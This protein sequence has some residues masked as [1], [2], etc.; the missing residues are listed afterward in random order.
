MGFS[1]SSPK[2]YSKVICLEAVNVTFGVAILTGIFAGWLIAMVLAHRLPDPRADW[3]YYW[4]RR[5]GVR[6]EPCAGDLRIARQTK[7][8]TVHSNTDFRESDVV[9]HKH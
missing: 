8:G 1:P 3:Q 5:P 9:V 4:R 6:S 7:L 2:L